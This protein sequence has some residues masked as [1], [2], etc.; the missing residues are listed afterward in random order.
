[1]VVHQP[2]IPV[3]PVAKEILSKTKFL[4]S[5]RAAHDTA[6]DNRRSGKDTEK[7]RTLTFHLPGK[8]LNRSSHSRRSKNPTQRPDISAITLQPLVT[9]P[10]SMVPDELGIIQTRRSFGAPSHHD[11]SV[12]SDE[13]EAN[14]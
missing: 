3:A 2:L 10:E 6:F 1:M 13:V 12:P 4:G 14:P 11:D 5:S 7:K 9:E 8:G